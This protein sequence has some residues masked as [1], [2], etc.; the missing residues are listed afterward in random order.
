MPIP[1]AAKGRHLTASRAMF[2]ASET[3]RSDVRASSQSPAS[4][5]WSAVCSDAA[6]AA[7]DEW[8]VAMA[9]SSGEVIASLANLWKAPGV[10]GGGFDGE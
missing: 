9:A 10:K 6:W 2:T 4:A 1:M 8:P 3:L 7:S 5:T